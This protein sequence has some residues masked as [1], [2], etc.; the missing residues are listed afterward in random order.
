MGR[1]NELF[2]KSMTTQQI[3][4]GDCLEIMRGFADKSFDLVLTDPP[5]GT[6]KIE[7]D[8]VVNFENMW[9]ELKRIVKDNGAIVMT[10]SQPFTTDLINSNREW[11]KCCWVWSKMHG[12]NAM[13]CN[14]QPLKLHEDICVFGKGK[15]NYYPQ[16][17]TGRLRLKGGTT[18]SEH[19]WSV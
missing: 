2:Q 12:G 17:R 18:N 8:N 14:V 1:T 9:N 11:F 13:L 10:A 15:V 5:Y 7:W 6:T 4:N 19:G 3:I 16:M